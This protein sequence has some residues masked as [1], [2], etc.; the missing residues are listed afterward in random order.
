[1]TQ[2]NA[3]FYTRPDVYGL[4]FIHAK[5]VT[6][7][8]ARHVHDYFVLGIIEAGLQTFSYRGAKHATATRGIIILNPDEPHTGEAVT[9][10]G[11][12]YKALYPPAELM[13]F[14]ASEIA[15]KPN[16][17][18]FFSTPIIYDDMLARR[19]LALHHALITPNSALEG[20][21]GVLNVL[22]E[23]A[24]HYADTRLTTT[25]LGREREAVRQIRDYIEAH[26]NENISLTALARLVSFSPYYLARVFRAEVGIPPHAYLESIRIRQAQ[27]LLFLGQ[28]LA[29]VAYATGFAHQSHFTNRFKRFVGVTPSQYLKQGKIMQD[30]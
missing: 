19:L 2:D 25:R 16:G 12:T 14:V 4:E 7:R 28:S 8:F 6:H 23:L 20:E 21:T 18:P 30:G 9:P 15:G 17:V 3:Q 27:R 22:G 11:F 13:R 29:E 10:E 26:Y 5:F 1:M 24:R